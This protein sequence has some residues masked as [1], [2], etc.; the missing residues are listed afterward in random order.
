MTEKRFRQDDGSIERARRLRRESTP[1]E[2]HFWSIVRNRGIAG[3]KFRRQ[4][5]FGP[6]V[7]DFACHHAK[8]I[9]E[10]DGDTHSLPDGEAHDARRTAYIIQEGYR[11]MRFTNAEVIGNLDGVASALAAALAPSPSHSTAPSGP[12]PLPRRGE[13]A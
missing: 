6:Y 11:V 7:A 9:V 3:C 1:A 13:E 12:L 10:I 5:R 4:Q 2:A 8:L